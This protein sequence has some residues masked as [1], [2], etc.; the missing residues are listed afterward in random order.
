MPLIIA[1]RSSEERQICYVHMYCPPGATRMAQIATLVRYR[2]RPLEVSATPVRIPNLKNPQLQ[3][4][5]ADDNDVIMMDLVPILAGC[6][7]DERPATRMPRGK[8]KR[9]STVLWLIHLPR[10]ATTMRQ[11]FLQTLAS[12]ARVHAAPSNVS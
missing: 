4:R 2:A 7:V 10:T 3:G 9:F 1:L 5:Q 12:P 6:S 11:S 8:R